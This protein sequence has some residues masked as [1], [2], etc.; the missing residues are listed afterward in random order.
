MI[1]NTRFIYEKLRIKSF[2]GTIAN[3]AIFDKKAEKL[4]DGKNQMTDTRALLI[5]NLE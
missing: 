2:Y 5:T 1:K 4:V 3:I